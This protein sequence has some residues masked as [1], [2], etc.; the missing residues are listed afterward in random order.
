[1]A[2]AAQDDGSG[3]G[4][5]RGLGRAGIALALALF[6]A[7]AQPL[8]ASAH[9]A[10]DSFLSLVERP[11][12]A[13]GFDG[14]WAIALRDL[15]P[16][17]GLDADDDAR[18]TW[19]EVAARLPAIEAYAFARLSLATGDRP[20]AIRAAPALV[21][22]L[23]GL[24]HL[25]LP[26][27]ADCPRPAAPAGAEPPSL[28]LGYRLF[29]DVDRQ[30]RGL[31]QVS[32]GGRV[33]TTVMSPERPAW[34]LAA[35]GAAGASDADRGQAA[36]RAADLAAY[37]VDGVRHILFGFDHLLFLV[38]LLLPAVLRPD[39]SGWRPVARPRAAAVAVAKLVTAFTLAHSLTL[40]LATFGWLTL[41]PRVVEPLI[42]LS[43][44][45][46]ALNNVVPM[47]RR[48]LWLMAFAFGLV[49]GIG[50]ADALRHL[51]LPPAELIWPLVGFNL[52]VELGQLALVA[53]VLPP[54]LML[55]RQRLYQPLAL[56]SGSLAI[57]AV[58]S[59]WLVER[60][61]GIV[62]LV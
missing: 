15:A 2:R 47:V 55:R 39:G 50:F 27:R 20:C 58:A 21:E 7:L 18:L 26:F 45:F 56:R 22:R 61:T 4:G 46:T 59:L 12:P 14:R 32:G 31:V 8:P 52:G 51:G 3:R 9:R 19:G 35:T 24:A 34:V 48:G 40:A 33:A 23:G 60:A 41:P 25:V 44:V 1:M 38:T 49:H 57:A 5:G 53:L 29:F 28:N 13:P 17:L 37:V 42:A 36:S 16:V 54:M 30:H 43:I 10:S 6:A 62:L 11:G